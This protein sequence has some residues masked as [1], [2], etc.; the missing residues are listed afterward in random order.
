M[1]GP[2][3]AMVAQRKGVHG[4][5]C[6]RTLARLCCFDRRRHSRMKFQTEPVI[7]VSFNET[8]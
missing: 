1:N 6:R 7:Y 2:D 3:V 8:P 5:L 4:T